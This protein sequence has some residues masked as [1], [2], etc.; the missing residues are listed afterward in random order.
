MDI[1]VDRIPDAVSV[2]SKAV[3]A[4]DG[5]PVVLVPGKDG[6]RPVSIELLARNPDEVA[7]RGIEAGTQVALVDNL[8]DDAKKGGSK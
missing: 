1:I 3:F 6:V 8:R 4:R 7:V 5:K 2:P